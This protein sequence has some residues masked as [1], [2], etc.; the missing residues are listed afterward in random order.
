MHR[1]VFIKS[2]LAGLSGTLL[3]DAAC[4][5]ASHQTKLDTRLKGAFRSPEKNGW[6]F[7]HLEGTPAEIG[8]QHGYL[9]ADRIEDTAKVTVLEQT[10]GSEY[11]WSFFRDAAKNMMWPKIEAEYREELQ[12]IADG[13]RAHGS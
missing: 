11:G 9:L 5:S 13:L 6:T 1:R 10:H 3:L 8:Y 2:S 7:V 12:G 4:K